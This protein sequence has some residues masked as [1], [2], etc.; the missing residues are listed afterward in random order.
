MTTASVE[1]FNNE[2]VS[3]NKSIYDKTTIIPDLIK[4][5]MNQNTPAQTES[6]YIAQP[7][8]ES[9]IKEMTTLQTDKAIAEKEVLELTTEYTMMTTANDPT[10]VSE[11]AI[12]TTEVPKEILLKTD[13]NKRT[14]TSVDLSADLTTP[15]S[16]EEVFT[17]SNEV[18][19]TKQSISTFNLLN[20]V[21]EETTQ[22]PA[23]DS[24]APEQD[25]RLEVNVNGGGDQTNDTLTVTESGS[26]YNKSSTTIK[27]EILELTTELNEISTMSYE[28]N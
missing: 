7:S 25:V 11:T 27:P 15:S 1:L 10:L 23:M 16:V 28:Q 19:S 20:D 22:K 17:L 12:L 4:T 8:T 24:E 14:T 6:E 3:E 21:Q 13:E 9:S 26:E 18:P 2:T 5:E